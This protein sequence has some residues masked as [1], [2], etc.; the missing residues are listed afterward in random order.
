MCSKIF[1]KKGLKE[2]RRHLRST[3]TSAEAVLWLSLKNKQL[4]G[5][6]FRRQHSIGNYIV[7]F[8]CPS[9]KLVIELDGEYHFLYGGYMN[10]VDRD[11]YLKV[12]GIK[13]LRFENYMVF[14]HLEVVL[15]EIKSYLIK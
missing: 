15:E 12:L 8:Y 11:N 13:V 3:G 10:D 7:D 2:N 9:D 1:N 5:K 14:D 6:R 4:N